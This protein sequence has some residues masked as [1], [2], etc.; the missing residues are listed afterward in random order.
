MFLSV[1]T[2]VPWVGQLVACLSPQRPQLDLREVHV[3]YVV[4]KVALIQAFL[5]ILWFSLISFHHHNRRHI[6]SVFDSVVKIVQFK[7]YFRMDI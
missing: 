4:D 5:R 3:R 2:G 6:M 7:I 1:F